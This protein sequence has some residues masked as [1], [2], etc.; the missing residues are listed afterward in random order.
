MVIVK[1]EAQCAQT[2]S[3]AARVDVDERL[4]LARCAVLHAFMI[5]AAS[6]LAA[7]IVTVCALMVIVDTEHRVRPERIDPRT[8]WIWRARGRAIEWAIERAKE[9]LPGM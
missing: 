9:V 2:P 5:A 8:H 4:D 6:A 3:T 1:C 7:I